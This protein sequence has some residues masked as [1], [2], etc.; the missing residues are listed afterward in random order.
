V[1]RCRG[2]HEAAE[3]YLTE[4]VGV[5]HEADAVLEGRT[6]LSIAALRR[7]Q[8][9]QDEQIAA[10]EQAT[11]LFQ[12]CGAA[13][14]EARALAALAQVMAERADSAAADSAWKRIERLYA[15]AGLPD[16][17]RIHRRPAR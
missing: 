1:A 8:G 16:E 5:A 3:R 15:L 9:K 4:A 14:L 2:E 10:L 17:D 13:H 12:G 11:H 7:D 6:W